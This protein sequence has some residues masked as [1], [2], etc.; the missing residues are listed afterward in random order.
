MKVKEIFEYAIN[1]GKEAD[2]RGVEGVKKAL[3]RE[4]KRY[5]ELKEEEKK[6]YDTV[7]L[8]NPYADSRILCGDEEREVKR[9]LMG[10][11][12]DTAEVL[13]ADRL[14]AKG[15]QIDLIVGHHPRG[16]ALAA[17]YDVMHLQADFYHLHGLPINVAEGL[18][19][20]RIEEVERAVLP[21]NH[22][23]SVDAARLLGFPF[24][25]LHSPSDNVVQR[26]VQE[27]LDRGEPETLGDV[28]SLLKKIPEYKRA[29]ALNFG[30][31][32]LAGKK[33]NRCGKVV[34]KMTGGTEGAKEIYEKMVEQGVGTWVC[35]HMKEESLKLAKEHNLNVIIA[36]HMSSDSLGMILLMSDIE[37]SGVEIIR[38]SGLL[39]HT[40]V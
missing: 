31:K 30:P 11:N 21:L 6:E 5:E 12:I 8:W 10:I 7:R 14:T 22:N 28:I 38:C 23:Q 17:L 1:K 25:C 36:G 3:E 35:M 27:H 34:V 37:K 32:I 24:M 4:K 33:E 26:F 2:P 40:D 39:P 19:A 15:K 29:T 16:K 18:M 9:I 13:L 20:P